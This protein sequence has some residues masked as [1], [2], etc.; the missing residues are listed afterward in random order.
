M[1]SWPGKAWLGQARPGLAGLGKARQGM[2]F[3]TT[4]MKRG[5]LKLKLCRKDEASVVRMAR[6]HDR[7]IYVQVAL[8]LASRLH[9]LEMRI[10]ELTKQRKLTENK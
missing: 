2:G 8:L 1:K 6:Q 10:Y 4:N 9:R 3:L 7:D 5:K